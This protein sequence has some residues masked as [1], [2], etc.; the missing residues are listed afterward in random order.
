M[1]T[2]E[3]IATPANLN[4]P[5][6]DVRG[7]EKRYGSFRALRGVDL[8]V[9]GGTIYGLLGP[10]GAGKSTLI[11]ALVGASR[12]SAGQL[13]VLGLD[14]VRDARRLRP[15]LGYMPQA[16]ALYED[17]SA[18][19]NIRFFAEAH[20]LPEIEQKVDAAVDFVALTARQ[21]DPVYAF[22]GG[23]K[24]RVSLACAIVH[25]P[26]VL[27]LDE[28]TAGVDPKLKEG[29]WRHFRDL[30]A[31]GVTLFISTHLMDEALLCDQLT[32]LRQGKVLVTA[33][34]GEIMQRGETTVDV[35]RGDVRDRVT[36]R[37]SFDE[38]P[39][40]LRSY[41]LDPTVTRIELHEESLESIIV[42]M[43]EGEEGCGARS[44]SPDGCTG[45]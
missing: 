7:L 15:R 35:W 40:V 9:P 33:P 14:P 22:S 25:Q 42:E 18:R 2:T 1:T 21:R 28:P 8:Q 19:D 30:A 34:P 23:M 38:L 29:F 10:N 45:N 41:G 39:R 31:S 3:R 5:S 24:Q 12:P 6:V 36:V 26:E 32:V 4:T 17:L 13:R 16:P 11:K 43:I 20:S 27:F 44:S 37:H